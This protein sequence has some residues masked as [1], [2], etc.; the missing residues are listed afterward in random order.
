MA[1]KNA[2]RQELRAVSLMQSERQTAPGASSEWLLH[3]RPE[4]G[5]AVP[6]HAL[7]NKMIGVRTYLPPRR[8]DENYGQQGQSGR[9]WTM[10]LRAV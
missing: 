3:Q 2:T 5:L 10:L 7:S 8:W 1:C 9:E 6:E 4:Q